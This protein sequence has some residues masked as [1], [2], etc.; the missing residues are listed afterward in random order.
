MQAYS[1]TSGLYVQFG[2]SSL[3]LPHVVAKS[4]LAKTIAQPK[5]LATLS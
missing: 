2:I 1:L 5:S 3:F 4:G